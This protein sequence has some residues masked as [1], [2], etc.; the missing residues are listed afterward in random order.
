MKLLDYYLYFIRDLREQLEADE[1]RWG[2]EWKRHPIEGSVNWPHQNDRV[3][4]R[5]EQYY[6]D[7]KYND[8]PIPWLK[9]CGNAFIAW[10][11]ERDP[12][13]YMK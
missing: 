8:V 13:G 6:K 11:R 9:V 10:V 3:M 5:I 4:K 2:D 12:D 7:W 1:K